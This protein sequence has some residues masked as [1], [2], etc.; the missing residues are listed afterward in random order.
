MTNANETYQF[1]N[2]SEGYLRRLESAGWRPE[3]GAVLGMLHRYGVRTESR[4]LDFG[5]GVGD[6]AATLARAGYRAVGADIS[7]LFVQSALARYPHLPFVALDTG[8]HLPMP[9]GEFA[10]VTAIN[11]IEHV[12][13]PA[14]ALQEMVR[15]LQPGGLLVLTFPNLLSPLRPLKRF[16]AR[17]R[18]PK[19]GPESG[20]TT[21][22]ALS[23]LV[24][25]VGLMAT[26]SVSGR[27]HFLPRPAD[28]ANAERYRL[29]GYGADYDAV[30]L[31]NPVDV[32]MRLRQ[33]GLRI[34][35][36]RGIPGAAERSQAINRLRQILPP[37]LTSPILLVARSAGWQ[38]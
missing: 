10:A 16:L 25:N 37:A 35:E 28:F 4:V 8:A 21:A 5:C 14:E 7:V 3:Y 11:T 26:S 31:C 22:E 12:A 38:P 2:R 23:L 32:A 33:L 1:Y 27:P 17:S 20:D 6:M 15:L 19:Y 36:L 30:W 34:L 9:S 13:R 18:R 24:R 29:L